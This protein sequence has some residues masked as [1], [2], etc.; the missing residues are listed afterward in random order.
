MGVA[1]YRALFSSALALASAD[2]PW[3]RG[4]HIQ[5]GGTLEGFAELKTKL[6]GEQI[7]EGEVALVADLLGLIVTFIG[8]T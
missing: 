5:A 6:S 1:G 4:L 3:L 2:V 7:T 8:P